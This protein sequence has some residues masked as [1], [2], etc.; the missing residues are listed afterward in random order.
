MTKIQNSSITSSQ[1]PVLFAVNPD[2]SSPT[3]DL[4]SVLMVPP[5][6]ESLYMESYSTQPS[7]SGFLLY[8]ILQHPERSF[9][10]INLPTSLRLCSSPERHCRVWPL[11]IVPACLD[12]QD[13]WLLNLV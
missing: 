6:P 13:G 8:P 10:N 3:P 12:R 1:V 4:L 9:Q 11:P 5:P 7:D 2:P